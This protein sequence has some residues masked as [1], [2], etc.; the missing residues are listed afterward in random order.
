MKKTAVFFVLFCALL[1]F[2]FSQSQE[3]RFALVI[4]NGNYVE[5]GKLGNPKNDAIDMA[6]A[7]ESLGFEIDLLVDAGLAEMEDSVVR[8]G[9]KLGSSP[10]AVGFF[11]YAGH[12]VQSGGINYLIPAD[13]RVP[14]ESFL[15]TKALAAQTVMDTLQSA[16]NGLN[17]IVLDACR[18][19]PFGW[20]RSGSRG[21]S[22]VG[23]QPEGSIIVYATSAG[24]VALDGDGRN[25][26]FTQELLK[27]LA[28]PD[29]EVKELF[30]RTGAGVKTATG[31]KQIPAVYNQFFDNA[32]LGSTGF[33]RSGIPK[34]TPS[35]S[36]Q[37]QQMVVAVARPAELMIKA[38][39][40]GADI[41]IDGIMK[42]KAPL[43]VQGV[44]SERSIIIEARSASHVG[45]L[46]LMLKG[47]EL[48]EVNVVM[49]RMTG[50]LVI[51]PNESAVR[52]YLDGEDK[53]ELGSGILRGL[54]VGTRHLELVGA[55]TYWK[56]SVM[57]MPDT[58]VKVD[59][60]V[61][62][63]GSV[64]VIA[65]EGSPILITGAGGQ[66]SL[67]GTGV[68]DR[69]PVG[70]YAVRAGGG[71]FLPVTGQITVHRG[72][73]N[74]WEPYMG[75]SI[76]FSVQPVDVECVL[77]TGQVV[78]TDKPA[79]DIPPGTWKAVFR[80]SGYRDLTMP[81]NVELGKTTK[82]SAKLEKLTPGSLTVTDFGAEI[83]LTIGDTKFR[84][85]SGADGSIK[86]AGI[87]AGYALD[88]SLETTH[89]STPLKLSGIILGEG[90]NLRLD[91][92]SYRTWLASALS[93]ERDVVVK[94]LSAKRGKNA[95][96]IASLAT[97]ILGVA[98]GGAVYILGVE[99]GKAYDSALDSAGALEARKQVELYGNL[100]AVAGGLGGT[101]FA[102]A[103]ILFMGG[104]DPRML[105]ASLD[106]L[107]EQI[108]ALGK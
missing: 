94:T 26:V 68:I 11:Y 98:A 72:S 73:A 53:G 22:V 30:N 48:R 6:A 88:L 63:F 96:A 3:R 21:L 43:L 23:T 89:A 81:I 60:Q 78:G 76:D 87:P 61:M 70:T 12:G 105:Q 8:L 85:Q 24:S 90:K 99:A 37:A 57:I 102:L 52:V 56:G 39:E 45:N 41:Y 79:T 31:G 58:T 4:G 82:I 69:I 97:G 100:L 17:L 28:I 10:G 35:V 92:A 59:P 65:P 25:G 2:A 9:N 51:S 1:S 40:Q 67:T 74:Q 50:N 19:N 83:A 32:Y 54:P 75:G 84:G 13:A 101:G 106:S 44:S 38:S 103:P 36:G 14:S 104:P 95:L 77:E 20:S 42:G 86:F 66:W 18:D 80:L 71:A 33:E 29:L 5:L 47:G 62:P 91:P 7:L 49:A 34:P 46:E 64:K 15:K 16:R 27:N 55:D 108:R 93:T 107:D